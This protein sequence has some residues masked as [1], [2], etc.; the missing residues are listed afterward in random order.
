MKRLLQKKTIN[1]TINYVN[2]F[3][4]DLLIRNL[5]TDTHNSIN[6]TNMCTLIAKVQMMTASDWIQ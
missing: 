3:S 5:R 4:K 2:F 1:I 6:F